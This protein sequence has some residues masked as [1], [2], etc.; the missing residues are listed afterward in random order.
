MFGN[1]SASGP[2]LCVT[3]ENFDALI[4]FELAEKKNHLHNTRKSHCIFFLVFLRVFLCG[5]DAIKIACRKGRPTLTGDILTRSLPLVAFRFYFFEEF[6]RSCNVPD[7]ALV[8]VY[9]FHLSSRLIAAPRSRE[10]I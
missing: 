1:G 2:S 6:I 10:F 5:F 3:V 9:R 4:D 7:S 8:L